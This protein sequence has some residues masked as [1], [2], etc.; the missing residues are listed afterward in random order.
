MA[1]APNKIRSRAALVGGPASPLLAFEDSILA[2]HRSSTAGSI[3]AL[4]RRIAKARGWL[5]RR[6][7]LAA[8]N[9]GGPPATVILAPA[10]S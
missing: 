7:G 2:L 10:F 1:G 4:K 8:Q 3:D 5:R 6:H 9:R